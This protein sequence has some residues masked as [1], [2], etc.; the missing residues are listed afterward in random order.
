MEHQQHHQCKSC[1]QLQDGGYF[2][3]GAYNVIENPPDGQT[4]GTTG[5]L[6]RYAPEA[7]IA[8]PNPSNLPKLDLFP[9]PCSSVLSVSFNLPEPE[10]SSVVIYDLSGRLVDTVADEIF[11]AGENTL[12]WSVS[13]GVPS[14]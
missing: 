1:L 3:C 5:F 2:T 8:E 4:K 9:N 10:T 6:V 14:G 11:P 7:G 12:E 13:A